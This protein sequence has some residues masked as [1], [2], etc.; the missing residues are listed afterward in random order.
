MLSSTWA[1]NHT[2]AHYANNLNLRAARDLLVTLSTGAVG[3]STPPHHKRHLPAS[4]LVDGHRH[5]GHP[6]AG[7]PG[8]RNIYYRG[9]S[10]PVL[11]SSDPGCDTLEALWRRLDEMQGVE[12]IAIP[13]HSA[14]AMM[15]VDWSAGW[16]PRYETAVEIYSVWGNSEKPAA[17]G[18]PRPIEA[19]DGEMSG[20]HVRDALAMGYRFGFV[21]GGDIHDGRPGDELHNES[22]PQPRDPRSLPQGFAACFAPEK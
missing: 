20:R 3:H 9:P 1:D 19:C 5:L 21:G 7:A 8:H 4:P 16:N 2:A 11:R 10:G 13:H 14:N 17:E 6:P 12:A 15:G 22:Y 18:N